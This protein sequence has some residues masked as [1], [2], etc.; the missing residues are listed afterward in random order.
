VCK[1]KILCVKKKYCV[2]V[3]QWCACVCDYVLSEPPPMTMI[4]MH[5]KTPLYLFS[6]ARLPEAS[7]LLSN[8]AMVIGPTP[9]GTGVILL[10]TLRT[11][12]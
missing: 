11:F 1:E 9:P 7:V 8:I 2:L 10:A 12:S 4:K 3:Y 6:S 5:V